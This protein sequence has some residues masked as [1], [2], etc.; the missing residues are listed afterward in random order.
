MGARP[1]RV[2]VAAGG[3]VD[4]LWQ[5]VGQVEQVAGDPDSREELGLRELALFI[6]RIFFEQFLAHFPDDWHLEDLVT[7]GPRCRIHI[8]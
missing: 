6:K 8:K 3:A 1:G 4:G 7:R 5:L 2:R